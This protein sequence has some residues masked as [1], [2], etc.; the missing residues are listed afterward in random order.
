MVLSI[1]APDGAETEY[2]PPLRFRSGP[3]ASSGEREASPGARIRFARIIAADGA[4]VFR[5]PGRYLLCLLSP[6]TASADSG[7]A[8]LSDSLALVFSL[9]VRESDKRAYSILSRDPGEYGLA[10][11]LEGGR[12]LKSGMAILEQLAAFPNAYRRTAAF[13]LSSDWSQDS[14]IAPAADPGPWIWRR[15]LDSRN[16][17]CGRATTFRC[18]TPI[19]SARRWEILTR[20][21]SSASGLR[22]VRDS[23]AAFESRLTP[24]QSARL[25][26][27]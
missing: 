1:T 23:L 4:L 19:V 26:A 27:F 13:V 8:V 16:G 15:P 21:D 24:A 25:R 10:V 7:R 14:S 5:K 18:G 12:Q 20:R 22:P 3:D 17:I 9:P 2:R 11:Y 6:R